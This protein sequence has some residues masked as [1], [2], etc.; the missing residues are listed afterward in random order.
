MRLLSEYTGRGATQART[1]FNDNLITVVVQDLMTKGEHSLIR[2]GKGDLVLET[3]R[4]YQDSMGDELSAGVEDITGRKV[5]A[6]LSA[7]HLEPDIAIELQARA[8]RRLTLGGAARAAAASRTAARAPGSRGARR[9][10]PAWR[11]RGIDRPALA[12][13]RS[14]T[15]GA[16]PR[17]QLGSI[18]TASPLATSARLMVASFAVADVGVEARA[19]DMRWMISSQPISACPA[20][21]ASPAS[22]ASGTA[23]G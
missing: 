10:R 17:A 4:A 19:R 7:N 2:N 12:I 13:A 15:S 18:D 14:A 6:F 16:G 21:H 20:V 11:R 8:G 1:H 5:I 9:P 22:D 3:R 23:S